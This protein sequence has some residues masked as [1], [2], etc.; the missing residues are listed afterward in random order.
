MSFSFFL[1]L[2]AESSTPTNNN[3]Y[4]ISDDGVFVRDISRDV[5]FHGENTN[6]IIIYEGIEI[7]DC[8][9]NLNLC[10]SNVDM[11]LNRLSIDFCSNLIGCHEII[12]EIQYTK[13][14]LL[15]RSLVSFFVYSTTEYDYY[16]ES[17]IDDAKFKC[18]EQKSE[19]SILSYDEYFSFF[20]KN[21]N[22][23][24]LSPKAIL[25]S[26][27][28]IVEIGGNLLWVDSKNSDSQSNL[29]ELK[30]IFIELYIYETKEFIAT[31]QTDEFGNFSLNINF[32][33]ILVD[34]S[35]P[36]IE[37]HIIP[38]SDLFEIRNNF[39]IIY[40]KIFT[41]QFSYD[42]YSYDCSQVVGFDDDIDK[43][44]QIH[45]CLTLGEKFISEN[46]SDYNFPKFVVKFPNANDTVYDYTTNKLLLQSQYFND[47]DSILHEVGHY[48]FCQM[49][50]C[51]R[52]GISHSF[53]ENLALKTSIE[54][55]MYVSWFEG[56]AS[57][58]SVGVQ[59]YQDAFLHGIIH[60]GDLGFQYYNLTLNS[61]INT[62]PNTEY[63][64]TVVLLFLVNASLTKDT[65]NIIE[66]DESIE[67]I[68]DNNIHY[69]NDYLKYI[70]S[71]LENNFEKHLIYGEILTKLGLALDLSYKKINFCDD[72]IKLDFTSNFENSQNIPFEVEHE[73][74]IYSNCGE[75]LYKSSI[76]TEI[77]ADTDLALENEILAILKDFKLGYLE[78]EAICFAIVTSVECEY[79][80]NTYYSKLFS[81]DRIKINKI[82]SI[83]LV[84]N[85]VNL[86]QTANSNDY[87]CLELNS[88]IT[89][90]YNIEY[91]N[92]ESSNYIDDFVVIV[93]SSFNV[94]YN[95]NGD[96]T[97]ENIY[98]KKAVISVFLEENYTY[99]ILI[100]DSQESWGSSSS[101]KLTVCIDKTMNHYLVNNNWIADYN[102]Q[103]GFRTY[104]VLEYKYFG[105]YSLSFSFNTF[106][107]SD[108]NF[109]IYKIVS[110]N[111]IL[112]D[113]GI[114]DNNDRSNRIVLQIDSEQ[115]IYVYVEFPIMDNLLVIDTNRTTSPSITIIPDKLVQS[116]GS[117]GTDVLLNG[118]NY[119]SNHMTV[120][121]T[122]CMFLSDDSPSQLRTDY[123]W[124]VTDEQ[125]ATIS[126]FG[127]L[128]SKKIGYI[129]VYAIFKYDVSIFGTIKIY[130]NNDNNSEIVYLNFGLDCRI[131]GVASGT[132]ITECGG[133]VVPIDEYSD[134]DIFMLTAGYTRLI[135]L[136]D[137]SPNPFL[138]NFDWQSSD[139]N[140]A[141]VS[142]FGTIITKE[143]ITGEVTITGTYRYNTRFIVKINLLVY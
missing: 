40:K 122:K 103:Q 38:I 137:D 63:S 22:N 33:E 8:E 119:G 69:F 28:N 9:I 47:W 100:A 30:N 12:I 72:S 134:D 123:Y 85:Y 140:I 16:S 6:L 108:A 121:F 10:V 46:Y 35:I 143:N 115:K 66:F 65:N 133:Q 37:C 68:C 93:D 3:L 99:Y 84:D 20:N 107:M 61:Q 59:I 70:Y 13:E 142:S 29:H 48:F 120:G 1:T 117:V 102:C 114:I 77:S 112:L 109:K 129:F 135:C 95:L 26:N 44:I 60:V 27:V 51:D 128:Q 131:T 90:I 57:Y 79:Y 139:N 25:L 42:S 7:V 67:L 136:G 97:K 113:S 11:S 39:D 41:V 82:E 87:C 106:L 2:K 132:Y 24:T 75:L 64:E 92:S 98:N 4:F 50:G 125:T 80:Y 78:L 31:V 88:K 91:Y 118:G 34:G 71:E 5:V 124:F 45:Q 32:D 21:E 94:L 126:E 96:L 56:I 110:N 18:Y 62:N 127:T 130:I 58:F 53:G 141:I 43:S 81:I 15:E 101:C 83:D 23:L 105:E 138:Q 14:E 52:G 89:A 19:S 104:F 55:A 86:M 74:Y 73:L 17:S 36:T 49:I 54:D 76:D 116:G 111:L